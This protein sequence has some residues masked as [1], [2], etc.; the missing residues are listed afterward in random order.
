M[1][2]MGEPAGRGGKGRE[3]KGRG[4]EDGRARVLRHFKGEMAPSP[5]RT[6]PSAAGPPRFPGTEGSEGVSVPDLL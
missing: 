2:V 5:P 4:G 6:P 3:G 1:Y